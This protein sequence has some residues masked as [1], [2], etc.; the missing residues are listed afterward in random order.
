[1]YYQLR[2]TRGNAHPNSGGNLTSLMGTQSAITPQQMR[3]EEQTFWQAPD[4][5]QY[6]TGWHMIFQENDW[7]IRAVFEDQLMDVTFQYWEGAV[8]ILDTSSGA[9]VGRGYLEMVR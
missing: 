2:D 8:E 5:K 6:A 7:M 3:L 9:V 4:G 1:M